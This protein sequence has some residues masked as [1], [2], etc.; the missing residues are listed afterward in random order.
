MTTQPNWENRTLFHGDNLDVLRA[1]NSGTVDLIATDPPFNKGKDFHATPESLASGAKFQDRWSWKDD[2][3]QDWVDKLIDDYPTLMEAIESAKHAHSDGMGAF[4]CFMSVRLIEM[5][6]ILKDTGSIYL[7]CDPTASHYL[8]ACMDAIFGWKNFRNEI[9]WCYSPTGAGPKKSFHRKH[10][11]I[12]FY[13]RSDLSLFKR[14]YG[15]MTQAT[16]KRFTAQKD[17]NGR[18]YR[19]IG[20]KRTYLDENKGRPLPDWWND[21]PGGTQ[22]SAK[23][24]TGYPT[25]KP[26]KLYERIIKASSNQNDIVLDPFAGCATTCVAAE[27]LG[28]QW[29]GIDLWKGSHELV[30]NRLNKEGLETEDDKDK[31]FVFDDKVH[32]RTDVPERTDDGLEAVP[33]LVPPTLAK[34]AKYN[35]EKLSRDEIKTHLMDAQ[36]APNGFVC[37]AGCGREMEKEFMEIDHINPRADGGANDISNRILIC[38]PC[39]QSKKEK[40]TLSGLMHRNKKEKWMKDE[41]KAKAMQQNVRNLVEELKSRPEPKF[42]IFS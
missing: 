18:F 34:R 5:H 20:G 24:R 14:Q 37:C 32:Y 26:L 41:T 3:H 38:R 29:V 13:G 40:L 6:R 15:E 22:I 17:Q 25:Q 11:I 35:Y 12:L 1:M 42:E 8:K 7:H 28:R 19:D 31:L 27:R 39:N 36:K 2:V 33:Y 23:E 21:I 30:L 10:D 9:V 4:M 16:L